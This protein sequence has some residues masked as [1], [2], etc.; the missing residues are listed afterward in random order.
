MN[1][2]KA[3]DALENQADAVRDS[4]EIMADRM[5]SVDVQVEEREKIMPDSLGPKAMTSDTVGTA[6][7]K[8]K[9]A[10]G[11]H[12]DT[13]LGGRCLRVWDSDPESRCPYLL[14][15]VSLRDTLWQ[16][17]YFEDG[18]IFGG[19]NCMLEVSSFD[20]DG[21]PPRE[22]KVAATSGQHGGGGGGSDYE[23]VYIFTPGRAPRQLLKIKTADTDQMAGMG[24]EKVPLND[25][26]TGCTR[27]LT[28][29]GHEVVAGPIKTIGNYNRKDCPLTNLPAGRYRYQGGKVF[30]VRQ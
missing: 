20:W 7:I 28:V 5:Q 30:R 8:Q 26:Y 15:R 22:I 1:G 17:F 9:L 27:T 2:E 10:R 24:L 19:D 25:R 11:F 18:I 13:L 29:R 12:L 4:A 23:A 21:R 3:A 6:E 14:F 16:R